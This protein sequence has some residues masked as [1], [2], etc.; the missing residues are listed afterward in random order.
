MG[1]DKKSRITISPASAADSPRL[2]DQQPSGETLLNDC[3][4]AGSHW[5]SEGIWFINSSG[6]FILSC[7][8]DEANDDEDVLLEILWQDSAALLA[9]YYT[10]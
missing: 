9:D 7:I 10:Q 8:L 1:L 5:R 6:L 4:T 3:I 2:G